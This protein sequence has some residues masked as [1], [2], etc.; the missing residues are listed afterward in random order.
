ML[1]LNEKVTAVPE[2]VAVVT[3]TPLASNV[4]PV[5]SAGFPVPGADKVK[6]VIVIG[7]VLEFFN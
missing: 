4:T 5:I 7:E 3:G 1:P 6:L 2:K